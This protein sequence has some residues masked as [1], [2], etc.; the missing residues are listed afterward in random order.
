MFNLDGTICRYP[1]E[2]EAIQILRETNRADGASVRALF[3]TFAYRHH[4]QGDWESCRP[5][6]DGSIPFVGAVAL[7]RENYEYDCLEIAIGA[8]GIYIV[9]ADWPGDDI[10][11]D[12]AN[13]TVS[14]A[15]VPEGARTECEV[16]SIFEFRLTDRAVGDDLLASLYRGSPHTEAI[17]Q[18]LE[19]LLAGES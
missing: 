3:D 17:Q 14:A 8:R 15:F 4:A 12:H 13:V 5:L 2:R 18:V 9:I 10:H 11:G 19:N 6:T 1:A 16:I 7:H